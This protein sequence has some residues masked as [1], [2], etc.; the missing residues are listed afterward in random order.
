MKSWKSS[1][2]FLRRFFFNPSLG[3]PL[4]ALRIVIGYMVVLETALVFP[5]IDD[6]YGQLGYFQSHLMDALAGPSLPGVMAHLGVHNAAY[7]VF[8]RGF[9][10][11]HCLLGILFLVGFKTR[12]VSVGLWITQTLVVNSGYVS[13]YGVHRYLHNLIFLSMWLPMAQVWS[14]DSY[15]SPAPALPRR[16]CTFGLRLIQIFILMTYVDA[17]WSKAMGTDWWNGEAIWNALN[18]PEFNHFNFYWLS[19]VPWLAKALSRGTLLIETFY[20]VGVCLPRVGKVW[21]LAI[22]GMHLAIALFMG[23]TLFG[24]SLALVN[25][26]LFLIPA[27]ADATTLKR[28]CVGL[29]HFRTPSIQSLPG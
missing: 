21:V 13:V 17:G 29:H 26:V 12:R 27:S 28:H 18:L 19:R 3:F 4:A 8:L 7:S 10:L 5:N 24:T 14:F 23:L 11:L 25:A 16:A 1:A 6:L 15:F 2:A 20:F 9:Y 22:I